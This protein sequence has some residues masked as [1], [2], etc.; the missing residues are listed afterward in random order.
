MIELALHILDIAENSSRADATLI[1]ITLVEDMVNDILSLEI[2]DNGKGMDEDTIEK[3]MDPF[4]TTKKV[5]RVGLGLPMLKQAAITA[6][7]RF[8]IESHVG[9]G[10]RVFAQ[11]QHSHIDRQPIGDIPGCL[12]ALIIGNPDIDILYTH[13]K[14]DRAYTLDTSEIRSAL[15][16][17]PL[18]HREVLNVIKDNIIEGIAELNA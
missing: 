14:N 3:A 7:G 10:T 9:K 6:G 1:E 13:T 12:V 5:R 17:V 16:G 15:D 11:F 8:S 18:N 4:Y 2:K